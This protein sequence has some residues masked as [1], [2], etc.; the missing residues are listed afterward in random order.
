[1][2]LLVSA[3]N[4]YDAVNRNLD[5]EYA[6]IERAIVRGMKVLTALDYSFSNFTNK[7]NPLSGGH[8]YL[9]KDGFCYIWPI[10]MSRVQEVDEGNPPSELDYML[11]GI[12]KLCEK[13]SEINKLAEQKRASH[14]RCLF[15]MI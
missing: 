10:Q 11:V 15:F 14:H 2:V 7:E 4:Y 9:V 8:S 13:G 3:K 6:R 12:E 5:S 1:M